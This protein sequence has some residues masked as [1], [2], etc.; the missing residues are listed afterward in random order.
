MSETRIY[1][2]E[3]GT[4][5]GRWLIIGMLFV[6]DHGTLHSDLC[7]V[8]ERAQYFDHG[9]RRARYKETHFAK[10]RSPRDTEVAEAWIDRFLASGSFFRSVVIDW[11]IYEGRYFGDPFE[12]DALKMRRAYKK[13]AEMLLQPEVRALRD[14]R[15]YLDKLKILYDYD[16]IRSLKERFQHDERGEVRSRPRI[17]EFQATESWKDA[18]Q[19]LQLSDLLTGCV[20]Q[21]LV[22]STKLAKLRVT[23]YLYQRLQA[24]GV[25][26]RTPG[27][28]RGFG[29]HVR[30]HFPRFSEWFWK[31]TE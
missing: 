7:A 25:N 15:F 31:P 8:K 1:A 9:P 17:I 27:Y 6:P 22:P 28:W 5:G 20:H 13:W 14:A 26:G 30:K 10:L 21:S 29:S 16:V 11:S 12:P 24:H 23:N 3:S 4:H 2:D 18:N 19:C